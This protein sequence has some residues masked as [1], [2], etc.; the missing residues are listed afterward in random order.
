MLPLIS[1]QQLTKEYRRGTQV[2][3]ALDN[4]SFEVSQGEFVAIVGP[5]GS[6]KSTLLNLI[7]CMDTA[8]SG[9]LRVAGQDI[10]S[11]T[12]KLKVEFRRKCVGFV[13]QHFGL[14]PTLSVE[15]NILLPHVFAKSSGHEDIERLLARLNLADR[16]Q[17]RPAELS[18][19]EMQR[20]AIARALYN[21]PKLLLADEPTGNLDSATAGS[22]LALFHQLNSDGLSIIVVTHNPQL[23]DATNRQISLKDGR[24]IS[25]SKA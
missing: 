18:G 14:V 13:F 5:S 16:R 1:A 3:R 8:T 15:D 25:D 23:A 4:V 6:G 24:I 22:I 9:S 20:V 19:G 11:A 17:H 12:E 2:V 21:K 7:G 10:S